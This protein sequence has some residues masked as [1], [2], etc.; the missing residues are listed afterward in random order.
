MIKGEL[1]FR[2]CWKKG[3]IWMNARDCVRS[4][5]VRALVCVCLR[6]D[7]DAR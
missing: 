7:T 4:N 2:A 3:S 5:G 6:A 1:E